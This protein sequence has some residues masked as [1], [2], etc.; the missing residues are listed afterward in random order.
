MSLK[1]VLIVEDSPDDQ[2]L[3]KTAFRK[4]DKDIEVMCVF[5]G[6]EAIEALTDE[7]VTPDVILLDINM[8]RMGGLEFLQQHCQELNPEIPPI[9]VMLTSSEQESDKSK[10]LSYATVKDYLIKPIRKENIESL[11]ELIGSLNSK[12]DPVN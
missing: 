1:K 7:G 11:A 3:G 6:V 12:A 10:C 8:P 5:D 4:Y 2:F 9:V